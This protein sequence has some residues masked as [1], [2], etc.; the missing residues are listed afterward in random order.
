MRRL[1]VTLSLLFLVVGGILWG[2]YWYLTRIIKERVEA[3]F[4][5][6]SRVGEV[7]AGWRS[8]TLKDL[9][10][11]GRGGQEDLAISHVIIIPDIQS[12]LAGSLRLSSLDIHRPLI[13]FRRAPEGHLTFVPFTQE[14]EQ[15]GER[16]PLRIGT[17]QVSEGRMTVMD[18]P[19]TP[20]FHIEGIQVSLTPLSSPVVHERTWFRIEGRVPGERPGSLLAGGWIDLSRGDGAF[21]LQVASL[22]LVPLQ[23]Y[24]RRRTDT[25]I[26]R[27]F[28]DMKAEVTLEEDRI[29]APGTLRLSEITLVRSSGRRE[30]FLGVPRALLGKLFQNTQGPVELNFVVEGDL[31]DPSFNLRD[32]FITRVTVALAE[33]MGVGTVEIVNGG[34]DFERK[35]TGSKDKK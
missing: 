16:P 28:L 20:P 17:V 10:L 35:G 34:S 18:R 8:V 6:G 2:G 3:G 31:R 9:R 23:P 13:T 29:R 19:E 14:K 30:T 32:A 24:F 22:D 5:P 26:Q 12:F 1:L 11:Q 7:Q 27:G 15:W 33:K 25:A 4:G 21:T